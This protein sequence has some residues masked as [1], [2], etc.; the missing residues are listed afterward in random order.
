MDLRKFS[1]FSSLDEAQIELI[2]NDIY[3]KRFKAK[4]FV[5]YKGDLPDAMYFI[6]SGRLRITEITQDGREIGIGYIEAGNC[7]GEL[8]VI[9]NKPRSADIITVEP[10]EIG[11]LSQKKA[12]ELF[13]NVPA[14]AKAMMCHLASMVRKS[15]DHIML[16]TIPNAYQRV[17]AHIQELAKKDIAGMVIIDRLHRHQVIASMLNTSR[18][19]VSRALNYLERQ[20]I[21][22]KDLR[23]LIVRDPKGLQDLALNGMPDYKNQKD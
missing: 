22:E 4:E 21:V 16:L 15:N 9:D 8:S 10:S 12:Q 2:K 20:G 18:E 1:F 13:Y 23:R 3:K 7:F 6:L 14:V 17:F 5:C 19:T 11:Y